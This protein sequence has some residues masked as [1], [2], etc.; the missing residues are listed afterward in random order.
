MLT[1]DDFVT[2]NIATMASCDTW[3]KEMSREFSL[4]KGILWSLG[5]WPLD[6]GKNFAKLRALF[7]TVTQVNLKVHLLYI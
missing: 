3:N 6:R 5:A 4:Y 7:L 2:L 1:F